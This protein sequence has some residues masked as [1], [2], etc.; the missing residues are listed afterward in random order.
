MRGWQAARGLGPDQ[1][2]VTSGPQPLKGDACTDADR[3]RRRRF[4]ADGRRPDVSNAVS[5]HAGGGEPETVVDCAH[6]LTATT[7]LSVT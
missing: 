7:P 6:V 2:A 3:R 5:P 4:R 1:A